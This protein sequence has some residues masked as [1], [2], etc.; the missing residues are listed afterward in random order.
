[1][2][3]N[4]NTAGYDLYEITK[5]EWIIHIKNGDIFAGSFKK[6]IIHAITRLG[7]SMEE[8]EI[9]VTEM[10]KYGH[11]GAHFGTYKSFIYTFQ[12]EFKYEQA[13]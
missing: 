6:V 10:L 2:E 4:L 13:S 9:S 12:K 8:I 11:N 1:M 3:R 7:F 5:D